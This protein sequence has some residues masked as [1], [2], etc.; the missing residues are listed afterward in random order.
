MSQS[1]DELIRRAMQEGQFDNLPGKGKPLNLDD[2]P[3]EDPE[4]RMA[5][6]VLRSSG[7]SLPWIEVKRELEAAIESARSELQRSWQWRQT[8][9]QDEFFRTV[10]E[11]AVAH[12]QKRAAEINRDILSY[13]LKAPSARFH[14]TPL[15]AEQEIA[16]TTA[17][18][19][20]RL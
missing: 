20:D 11:Q 1:A 3:F 8:A 18:P 16:L 15:R 7:L 9:P 17:P 14:L 12:F 10:W 13:N 2:N 4:W 19:S 5:H 6:H